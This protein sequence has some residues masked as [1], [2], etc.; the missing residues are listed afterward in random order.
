MLYTIMGVPSTEA[1]APAGGGSGAARVGSTPAWLANGR[2]V[3]VTTGRLLTE[4]HIGLVGGR[5]AAVAA[6]LPPNQSDVVDLEGAYVLPGLISCHSHLSLVFPFSALDPGES[7][8]VTA[9]RSA[10]RATE[11]LAAGITT[12]RCVHEQNRVDL[13]LRQS[14]RRGWI[15]AP[16]IFGAGRAITTPTG[17]GI[18]SACVVAE[19]EAEFY[20]A[21][22]GELEAGADHIKIF[23][24]GGLARAGEDP[25]AAEMTDPELAG[26]VRAAH[27]HETYVVAHSGG[28]R[29]IRQALAQGVRCF[30]H[31]YELDTATA[32]LLADRGAYV[33]PT[34]VVTNSES[35]MRANAFEEATIANAAAAADEHLA[36]I[37]RAIEAGI[38]LLIGTDI[39]PGD[40]VDGV[41]ATVREMQLLAEAGLGRLG[42]L[43][44]ATI[45]A[46]R[47]LGAA[48]ELGRIVPG[49][50]ADLIAVRDDPLAD[51]A[52]LRPPA[53]VLQAGRVVA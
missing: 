5:I 33:T 21:A 18:G 50:H 12:L 29:A 37:K 34:L 52:A 3:D 48:D 32:T 14:W 45:V 36:S 22:R 38:P 40:D 42:A 9:F 8:A 47:L 51:L 41:S 7:P 44:A 10:R 24:T 26:A 11:A 46:A 27:E 15:E 25:G 1:A 53:L 2:I 4:R 23:I 35:W 19:G 39:P 16:R 31:A 20:R 28:S 30:E 6:R 49:F 17:H 13:W 43:Q